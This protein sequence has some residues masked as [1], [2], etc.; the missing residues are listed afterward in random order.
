VSDSQAIGGV[1]ATIKSVLEDRMEIPNGVTDVRITIGLP[2]SDQPEGTGVEHPRVNVFLYRV[3]RN[4][5]LTH[6]QMPGRGVRGAYGNPPLSLD[7]HYLLTGYGTVAIDD[8]FFDEI[9]AQ[10]LL[11][12]AMRVLHDHPVL[13]DQL[14]SVRAPLGRQLLHRSLRGAVES[15]KLTLDPLTIEDLSKIWTAVTLPYRTSAA[16]TA[17]VVQIESRRIPRSPRLVGDLPDAG[18]RVTVTAQ[19]WPRIDRVAVRRAGDDGERTHLYARIGDTLVL[20]GAAFGDEP[21][22]MVGETDV[23]DAV[24]RATPTTVEV[25]IPDLPALVPGAQPVR[26]QRVAGLASNVVA[27]LL[28]PTIDSVAIA[29]GEIT[30]TGERLFDPD[31]DCFALIGDRMVPSEGFGD[32]TAQEIVVPV[33]EGMAAGPYPVRVRVNDAESIDERT[34]DLP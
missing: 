34:V 10:F 4:Q 6:E 12:S 16:Y 9:T 28:V 18:P 30:I 7:L 11:G 27:F 23:T 24:Q 32:R 33:P 14:R 15:V 1:S 25:E 21:L 20:H 5:G 17:T 8:D 29:A 2:R 26:L 3:T 19:P 22:V 31:L 13:S